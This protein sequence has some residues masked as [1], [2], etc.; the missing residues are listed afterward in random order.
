M[1]ILIYILLLLIVNTT[2]VKS[3]VDTSTKKYR[4]SY[5]V[6]F[7]TGWGGQQWASNVLVNGE[8]AKSKILSFAYD[9]TRHKGYMENGNGIISDSY[10]LSYGKI[11]KSKIGLIRFSFGLSFTKIRKYEYVLL[12]YRCSLL[13]SLAS[14]FG[15]SCTEDIPYYDE[16]ITEKLTI[17]VPLDLQLMLSTKWCGIGIN[18]HI[19]L[20]PK[21]PYAALTLQA[22]LGRIR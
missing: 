1:K 9:N 18:P 21:F 10:S 8:I 6:D 5:W 2:V 19:N 12:G 13:G 7:G 22:S 11:N 14:F 4:R 15:G 3:Q 17:G 16:K 20:N